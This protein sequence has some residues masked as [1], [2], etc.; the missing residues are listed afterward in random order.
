[1]I[2]LNRQAKTVSKQTTKTLRQT[3]RHPYRRSRAY[4]IIR[5]LGLIINDRKIRTKETM[6]VS[7]T[8]FETKRYKRDNG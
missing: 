2:Y 4:N 8:S 7:N 1:M 6:C 3:D 5:L